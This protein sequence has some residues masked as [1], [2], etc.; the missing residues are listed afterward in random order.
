MV[1]LKQILQ[2]NED[3]QINTLRVDL[4]SNGTKFNVK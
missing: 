1:V 2:I 4:K 3:L